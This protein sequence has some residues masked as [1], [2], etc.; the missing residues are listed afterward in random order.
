MKNSEYGVSIEDEVSFEIWEYENYYKE[1]ERVNQLKR[2]REQ[3]CDFKYYKSDFEN[4]TDYF[5]YLMIYKK[6]QDE[7][8][9]K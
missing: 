3:M 5:N 7:R 8:I 9:H 2:E 4:H 6:Q 1:E